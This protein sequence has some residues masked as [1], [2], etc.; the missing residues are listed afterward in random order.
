MK[1]IILTIVIAAGICFAGG[2][3]EG[4]KAGYQAGFCYGKGACFKPFA[5]FCPFAGF[6]EDNFMGGYN[7]GFLEGLNNQ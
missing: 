5:P 6:G 2:F 4:Y 7:R 1:K 3:C